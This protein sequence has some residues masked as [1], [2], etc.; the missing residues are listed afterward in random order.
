MRYVRVGLLFLLSG[1]LQPLAFADD[2]AIASEALMAEILGCDFLDPAQCLYPF[3]N[4][5][6]TRNDISTPTQKRVNL[7]FAGMPTDEAGDPVKPDSWNLNDGYLPNQLGMT[8]VPGLRFDRRTGTI[9]G[10]PHR[11]RPES[12]R[13]PAASV[14]VINTRTGQRHPV[15]VSVD[16]AKRPNPDVNINPVY[17]K[18]YDGHAA[19]LIR[20]L[21][22]Y[23]EGTRYVIALRNLPA[24]RG[25]TLQ[26]GAGFDA[27]LEGGSGILNVQERCA[28]LRERVFPALSAAGVPTDD[29]YLAWDFTTASAENNARR[30]NHL[31]ETAFATLTPG[32]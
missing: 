11:T 28:H 17:R 20:P 5:H 15:S 7:P 29:L 2:E 16:L 4:D 14:V 6:F 12:F 26:A 25:G 22:S 21:E 31:L 24:A 19:L 27:C 10:A 9:P 18:D 23:E 13:N 1:L 32:E 30:M 3:P 8:R